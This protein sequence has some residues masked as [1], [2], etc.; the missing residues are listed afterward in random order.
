M[1]TGVCVTAGVVTLGAACIAC[2]T[3]NVTV[4]SVAACAFADCIEDCK[5]INN[6]WANKAPCCN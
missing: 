2:I 4:A 1:C 6:T 5:F 3:A